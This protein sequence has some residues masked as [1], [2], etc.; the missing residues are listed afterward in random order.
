MKIIVTSDNHGLKNELHHLR[1][2]YQDYD[3]FI[4][5]GDSEMTLKELSGWASVAGNNDYYAVLP[6]FRIVNVKGYKILV[7]HSHLIS[8]F[9]RTQRMIDMAKKH[10]CRMVCFGHT[11]IFTNEIRDGVHLINPGSMRYNR[12][13]SQPCYA[14]IHI[15]DNDFDNI[16]VKRV[17]LER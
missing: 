12:D 17:L 14:L 2:L 4:H 15:N 6:D 7:M 16:I 11:H 8:Y 9:N 1:E 3:A 10:D 5:C 13:G